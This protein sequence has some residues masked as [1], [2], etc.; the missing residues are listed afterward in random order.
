MNKWLKNI[1]YIWLLFCVENI[2][3][4]RTG[5]LFSRNYFPHE[6][7]AASQNWE[8]VQDVEGNLYFAND[9][10]V[11]VYNGLSWLLLTTQNESAVRSLAYSTK[12]KRVYIGASGDFGY[13]QPTTN[14]SLEYISLIKY[15]PE[16]E[17]KFEDVWSAHATQEGIVFQTD[18]NVYL[19]QPQKK[20]FQI[21]KTSDSSYF[22][23]T[24]YLQQ[25]TF[26]L[27]IEKGLMLLQNGNLKLARGG[28]YFKN[29]KIYTILSFKENEYLVGVRNEGLFWYKPKQ[30]NDII[31]P[32]KTE[33][34]TFLQKHQLYSGLALSED[35]LAIG[36]RTGGVAIIA[37]DGKLKEILDKSKGLADNNVRFMT[38]TQDK[39]IWIALNHGITKV[40]LYAPWRFWDEENGVT[41]IVR[42]ILVK[43][44]KVWVATSSGV[45]YKKNNENYFTQIEGIDTET[46]T[47]LALENGQI[48]VG[49]ND[50]IYEI[51][52]NISKNILKTRPKAV[53]KLYLSP[54]KDNIYAGLKGGLL[55]LKLPLQ[56]LKVKNFEFIEEEIYS[57]VETKSNEK[58]L[59]LGTFVKGVFELKF[60]KNN[61]TSA[62]NLKNYTLEHGLPSLR[63]NKLLLDNDENLICATRKGLYEFQHTEQRFVPTDKWG[64]NWAD[65]TFKIK[66]L[67]KIDETYWIVGD[68]QLYFNITEISKNNK[69]ELI[70]NDIWYRLLPEFSEIIVAPQTTQKIWV[71]GSEGVFYLDKSTFKYL[72]LPLKPHL[73][74]VI[75]GRDSLLYGGFG[76][77]ITPKIT[78][79]QATEI[80][81][82]FTSPI[83]ED[84]K[85]LQYA[86]ALTNKS[87]KNPIWRN[88]EVTNQVR[89]TNLLEGKYIFWVK[90]KDIFGQESAAV[91]YEFVVLPP[92]YRT[93]WAYFLFVIILFTCIYMVIKIFVFRYAQQQKKL[94]KLIK[95]RTEEVEIK[96]KDLEKQQT[97]LLNKNIEIDSQNKEIKSSITYASR[98]QQAM[99]PTLASINQGFPENFVMYK[100][101]DGVSGDFYWFSQTLMRPRFVKN[102]S[103]LDGKVSIFKDIL[104]GKKIICAVDCTGHGVPGA[105]ISLVGDAFLDEIINMEGITQ[106]SIILQELDQRIRSSLKQ[107]ENKITDGMDMAICIVDENNKTLEYAGANRPLVYMKN[108]ELHYIKGDR[109]GIG[110]YQFEV[111]NEDMPEQKNFTKH[112]IDLDSVVDFYIYSDGIED[113]FG[114]EKNRKFS[115][116]RL[117]ELIT[118]H[119]HL[120]MREQQKIY[121]QELMNWQGSFSQID[122]I[123][124]IGVR[125]DLEID[126]I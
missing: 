81:F 88:W 50:G 67:Y 101:R 4:Q 94:E 121:E 72:P 23:L 1:I 40:N 83:F 80:T 68:D 93:L 42:D 103:I 66:N 51:S 74:K 91:M 21:Y 20:S 11:L 10:G 106:A 49:A 59:W 64:I 124:L 70:Q 52:K 27:D 41:G 63:D 122:D 105:L 36:T 97:E 126:K 85:R 75:L 28:E 58:T 125:I 96:N 45:F 38:L 2:Y 30:N 33:A 118:L 120:P 84:E 79:E 34:D 13:L 86:Y 98:I 114:G 82:E 15:L 54:K 39:T 77:I 87:E 29:K 71:G 90:V 8:A 26:I 9:K 57:I 7:K 102:P 100:P 112:T 111:N 31:V 78:I 18:K 47:L 119:H 89:Y 22:F 56:N 43:D 61:Q 115:S 17:K 32:F 3:A 35:E 95:S 73:S 16:K 46:W 19:Y 5:K 37:K 110:G 99:L 25:K 6:Y 123:L 44:E 24:F 14:G 76:T 62:K 92:W 12:E 116:R 48:L 55:E 104:Q 107:D 69:K 65:D 117:K 53:L 113:Q 109:Y 108:N 60:D